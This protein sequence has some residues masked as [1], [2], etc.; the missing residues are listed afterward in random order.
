VVSM[1]GVDDPTLADAADTVA[2]VVDRLRAAGIPAAAPHID[3]SR[4]EYEHRSPLVGRAS[5]VAPPFV[6]RAAAEGVSAKGAFPTACEGPPGYVHGGWVALAF[7]EIL[8][9]ANAVAGHPGMTGRLTVRY[10]RP[11]P[12]RHEVVFTGRVERVDGRRILTRARLEADGAVTA[13]AEGL[14]VQPTDAR[15]REYF[16]DAAGE[17]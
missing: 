2:R 4:R 3:R 5:P 9:L 16:G 10:R 8:G 13:E 7:D 6:W 17:D 11:T 14:F 12:L 1:R 15:R